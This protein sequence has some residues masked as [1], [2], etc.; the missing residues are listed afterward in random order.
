MVPDRLPG[1]VDAHAHL[2]H[3]DFARDLDAVL[4]RARAA[5]LVRILV[6]GWDRA[7]SDAALAL[8]SRH[9]DLLDAAVGMHPHYVAAATSSDW[10]AIERMAA[11][12]GQI[13]AREGE[14]GLT[15]S[16]GVA[17][18]EP[19]GSAEDLLAMA[20]L[21]LMEQKTEKRR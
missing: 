13:C 9:P 21:A 16:Y 1:I 11:D 7:S 20:D 17:E 4:E 19:G 10:D 12:V 18:L 5:G 14:P 15:L 2:Q 6:P 8:A 3:E